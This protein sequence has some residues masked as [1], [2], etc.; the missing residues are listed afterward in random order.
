V[1]VVI[2]NGL[3]PFEFGVAC[4]VFGYDRSD[5]GVPWYR[6]LVCAAE[7]P[8]VTTETGFTID[9]V[10][11][12]DALARADTIIVPP[13]PTE[14]GPPEAL[15]AAL[16]AAHRRGARLMSMCTGAFVLAAAGVLDGRTATTHWRHVDEFASRFPAVKLDPAV[17]YVDDDNVLTSAGTAASIDLCLYVVRQ[18]FGAEI[19]NS[20]ARRMVVAPHRDGGQSQFVEEPLL[21]TD[22]ED[23]FAATFLWVQGNLSEPITVEDLARRSAMSPRTFARRFHNTTGTSPYRWL[24]RQRIIL[25]QRLLETTDLSVELVA[26][27]CGMGAAANLRDHFQRGIGTSPSAYRQTFCQLEPRVKG[28]VATA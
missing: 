27:R 13:L 28:S 17:L 19:A 9:T 22:A 3:S 25:A 16:Q 10:H 14:P 20:V 23:L 12:T 21:D 15:I 7:P 5:L 11:G 2:G 26:L 18:D 8:P 6:F 4:E 1:A 24:L